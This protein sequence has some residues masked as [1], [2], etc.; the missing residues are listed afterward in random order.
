MNA[1]VKT[2]SGVIFWQKNTKNGQ[3]VAAS[4]LKWAAA[5]PWLLRYRGRGGEFLKVPRSEKHTEAMRQGSKHAAAMVSYPNSLLH[6]I[7]DSA[8]EAAG[9][10]FLTLR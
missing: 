10:Q 6:L 2:D 5:E 4:G 1:R 3:S 8:F 7:P 9:H